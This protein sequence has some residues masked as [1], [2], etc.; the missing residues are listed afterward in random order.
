MSC[1]PRSRALASETPG[2][3]GR[4]RG[5]RSRNAVFT[6]HPQRPRRHQAAGDPHLPAPAKG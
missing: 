6:E 1:V 5:R 4:H 3:N 2:E